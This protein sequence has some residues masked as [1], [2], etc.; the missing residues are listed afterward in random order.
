MNKTGRLKFYCSIYNKEANIMSL[1]E[2]KNHLFIQ[3]PTEA[4]MVNKKEM[5][6]QSIEPELYT[7]MTGITLLSEEIKELV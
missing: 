6:V 2:I 4:Y 3:T 5:I 1:I 7:L